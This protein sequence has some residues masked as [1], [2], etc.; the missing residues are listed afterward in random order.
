ME[1]CTDPLSHELRFGLAR[2]S[3]SCNVLMNGTSPVPASL[4]SSCMCPLSFAVDGPLEVKSVTVCTTVCGTGEA[5]PLF[6]LLGACQKIFQLSSG[7][8]LAYS[9]F[10]FVQHR[11]ESRRHAV[12]RLWSMQR[13]TEGSRCSTTSSGQLLGLPVNKI[14]SLPK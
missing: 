13:R 12:S 4:P 14:R 1:L 8:K 10:P 11:P 2:R 3:S 7:N 5:T 6:Q 9:L